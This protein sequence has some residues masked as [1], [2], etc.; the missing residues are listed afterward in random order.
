MFILKKHRVAAR[1]IWH[2][3]GRVDEAA[4]ALGIKGSTLRRW[5]GDPDFRALVARESME[6]LLQ[7]TSG[8]VRWA[9]VA[10]A[11]LIRDLDGDSPAEA[12]QAARE[13]LKLAG[14]AHQRI[15]EGPP[16]PAEEEG[17]S[18]SIGD[19]VYSRRIADLPNDRLEQILKI[20]NGD[21]ATG[22]KTPR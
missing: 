12:R 2:H 4:I 18:A 10:V 16:L 6:P 17:R 20:L 19:D 3:G 11:R 22:G 15:V 7:A 8:V 9:P 13:I 1:A 21:G 14:E 5:L